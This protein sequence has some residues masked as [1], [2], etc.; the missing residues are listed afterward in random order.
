MSTLP[1]NGSHEQAALVDAYLDGDLNAAE[2]AQLAESLAADSSLVDTLLGRAEM[3][4]ALRRALVRRTA[5]PHAPNMPQARQHNAGMLAGLAAAAMIG[6]AV[7]AWFVWWG[8]DHASTD[9]RVSRSHAVAMLSDI[10]P[11]SVLNADSVVGGQS[12]SIGGDL[13][14]GPIRLTSGKAQIMFRSGAV[15]DMV[16]PCNFAMTGPNRGTLV[17]GLIQAFVPPNAHGFAIDTPT[18]LRVIDLGTRFTLQCGIDP[19]IGSDR[20]R[21]VDGIVQVEYAG[22]RVTLNASEIA[23]VRHG[24]LVITGTE[25]F[26]PGDSIYVDFGLDGPGGENSDGALSPGHWNNFSR[27]ISAGLSATTRLVDQAVRFDD[28]AITPVSISIVPDPGVR[29]GIG[30]LDDPST[31]DADPQ[32]PNSATRDTLYFI[33]TTPQRRLNLTIDGLNPALRYHVTLF[34]H[35]PAWEVRPSTIWSAQGQTVRY[36][37][38]ANTKAVTLSAL[39]P[40]A[41][42]R[43]TITGE[44][45]L[46]VAAAGQ[47]NLMKIQAVHAD[48]PAD[49][50]APRKETDR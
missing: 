48:E 2:F 1:G 31:L 20:V 12:L 19:A 50:I 22:Q 18:G 26:G 28:G 13:T 39:R 5:R 37:P 23:S 46:E 29:F 25:A 42:G 14:A 10:S 4:V 9:N 36:N 30:A 6:L 38:T 16:G 27:D 35:V 3:V 21:V 15:V 11:G 33:A 49:S 40:D 24:Q 8:G 44:R 17:R 43:L 41:D 7:T 34:G 32:F 47:L 45:G